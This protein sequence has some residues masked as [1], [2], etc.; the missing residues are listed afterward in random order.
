MYGKSIA[1]DPPQILTAE[2]S[3]AMASRLRELVEAALVTTGVSARRASLDVVGNDGLIRDIRAGRLPAIDRLDALFE[4]LGV[5]M[6]VGA[7]RKDDDHG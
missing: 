6:T 5:E 4:Y 3:A 7:S 2:R 1:S